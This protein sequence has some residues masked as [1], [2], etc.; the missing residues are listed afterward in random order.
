MVDLGTALKDM[1][2]QACGSFKGVFED[3]WSAAVEDSK[4]DSMTIVREL[5]RFMSKLAESQGTPIKKLT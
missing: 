4:Y 5:K 3:K 2:L 1:Y